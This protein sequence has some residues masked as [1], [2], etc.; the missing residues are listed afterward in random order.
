M[1][2]HMVEILT[3]QS[4]HKHSPNPPK[5]AKVR[6]NKNKIKS[7]SYILDRMIGSKNP[8]HATVPLTDL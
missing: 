1:S 4:Q 6:Q 5:E 2:S 8:S 7:L 3:L